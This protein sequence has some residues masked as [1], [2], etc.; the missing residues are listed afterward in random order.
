MI[1]LD[2]AIKLDLIELA[3]PRLLAGQP[4]PTSFHA[5]ANC[6]RHLVADPRVDLR[7][8]YDNIE[9]NLVNACRGI[10]RECRASILG[11]R[12]GNGNG[13]GN[14]GGGKWLGRLVGQWE[15]FEANVVGC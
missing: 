2:S 8:V 1:P 14:G 15:R 5:I 6:C 10:Q 3:I 13:N 11:D 7:K 12:N 4:T 9:E